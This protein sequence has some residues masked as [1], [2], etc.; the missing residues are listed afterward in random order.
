MY[1]YRK[2]LLNVAHKKTDK[3]FFSMGQ[4][5][6]VQNSLQRKI[7]EMKKT[8]S[9]FRDLK[10]IKESRMSIWTKEF[11]IRKAQYLT[12]I[13]YASSMLRY[14]TVDLEKLKYKLSIVHPME[15]VKNY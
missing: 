10:Q 15:K 7:N 8:F 11:G 9:Q 3:L 13:K 2:A 4:G 1:E 12:G 5:E 6:Q 14:K